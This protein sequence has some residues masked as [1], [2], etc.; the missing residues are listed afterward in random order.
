MDLVEKI[1]WIVLIVSLVSFGIHYVYAEDTID[2]LGFE[3]KNNPVT[4]IMEPPPIIQDRFHDS[5]F[6]M[7]YES[8][9]MWST[10]MH[11]YTGG[12]WFIPMRYYEY[13]DHF[14]KTPD[15]F[16][17]CNIFIEYRQY[18]GS[19][20]NPHQS[21]SALGYTSFDFSSSLHQYAYVMVFFEVTQ[22][23]PRITLCI[24][25]EDKPETEVTM[26]ITYLSMPDE[27]I[28]RIIMHEFGH[29][30]GIGHYVDDDR[31][32]NNIDSLMYPSLD[33]FGT[34]TS[35]IEVLDKEVLVVIYEE[36]GFGGMWGIPQRSILINDLI[37]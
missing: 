7:T 28:N 27:S 22:E 29:A 37:Q 6:I 34:N 16:R 23:N 33:P 4:C 18:N 3:H 17:E 24:G 10:E 32:S 11:D 5:I 31:R 8:V 2:T 35:M 13:E 14:D 15:D 25:C 12:D 26:D 30:L 9:R 20:G 1:L 21:K 36:D 19:D